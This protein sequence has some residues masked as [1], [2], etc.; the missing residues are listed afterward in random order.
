[1]QP[2]LSQARFASRHMC[3][4]HRLK[5]STSCESAVPGKEHIVGKAVPDNG[6]SNE[7]RGPSPHRDGESSV[8][9]IAHPVAA[10]LTAS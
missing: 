2:I 8:L 9:G 6:R 5:R 10:S 7:T 4:G 3:A 1:M